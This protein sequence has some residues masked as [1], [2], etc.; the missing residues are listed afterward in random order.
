MPQIQPLR[1]G[2]TA[3]GERER[4]GE[5]CSGLISLTQL[6]PL[7]FCLYRFDYIS[8]HNLSDDTAT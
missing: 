7:N 3:I 5:F 6:I 2:A 8:H 1:N 4:P